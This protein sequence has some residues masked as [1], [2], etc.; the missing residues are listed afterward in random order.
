MIAHGRGRIRNTTSVAGFEPGPMLNVCHSTKAFVL[1]YS[2]GLAVEL[3]D[4]GVTVT[5]LCPGP[6]DTDFFPKAGMLGVKAFQRGNLMAP[7]DMAEAG[8]EGVMSGMGY[9]TASRFPYATFVFISAPLPVGENG[10]PATPFGVVLEKAASGA[11]FLAGAPPESIREVWEAGPSLSSWTLGRTVVI[12]AT[13]RFPAGV[14]AGAARYF[15]IR[16]LGP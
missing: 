14:R 2:E 11:L 12:D 15:R 3:E 1:S 5:A 6:T 10:V 13:G 8:Y 9:A 7:Q 4:T 16:Y